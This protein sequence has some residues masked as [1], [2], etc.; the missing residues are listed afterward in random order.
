MSAIVS[1]YRV[2][3]ATLD[4][5]PTLIGM[6]NLMKYPGAELS[7]R[8]TE[9]QVAEASDNKLVGAVGLQIAGRQGRIYGETFDDFSASEQVRP[10]FWERL[11]SVAT[12]HGLLRLW[13]QETAPFWTQTGLRKA[14]AEALAKLPADWK[15][16]PG[17]WLHLKLKDDVEAVISADQEFMLFMQ[18]EKEQSQKTIRRAKALK[19]VASLVAF[20]VFLLVLAGGFLLLKRNPGILHH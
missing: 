16:F 1:G 12:N 7:K 10:L 14:D 13:T 5:V 15:A 18:S 17:D 6:W 2:R 19:V 9:F 8:V 20:V 4:D 3:R 11:Q